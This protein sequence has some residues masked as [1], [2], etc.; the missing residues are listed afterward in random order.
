MIDDRK[1]VQAV[2][3]DDDMCRAESILENE[4]HAIIL[5]VKMLTGHTIPFVAY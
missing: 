2:Q 3:H 4:T 5:N 1:S